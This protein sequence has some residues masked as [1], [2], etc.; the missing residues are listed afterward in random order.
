MTEHAREA[1]EGNFDPS[2][3]KHPDKYQRDLNPETFAGQNFGLEGPHF[4]KDAPTGD[5][6]KELYAMLPD[7]NKDDLR[8]LPILPEGVRLEQGAT[9]IDL[10][11]LEQGEFTATSDMTVQPGTYI[12]PKSEVD[13]ELW[14]RLR[15]A[16]V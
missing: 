14:N 11:N 6:F 7:L 2:G 8:A 4:E 9:Y 13:F 5:T 3:Q 16:I 12:V 15:N 10:S 1:P